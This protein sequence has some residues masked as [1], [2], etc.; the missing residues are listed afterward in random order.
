MI[1]SANGPADAKVCSFLMIGQSNMAGRGSL[2]E[3]EPI[4]N[5]NCYVLRIGYWQKMHEPIN[6]DRSTAGISLA[7]SF[8]DDLA[9][10]SGQPIG[11]IPCAYGGS[12]LR[13][14]MPGEILYEHAVAMT[15]IA[16]YT[17]N[18]SGILWH[19]GEN[20]CFPTFDEAA[21]RESFLSFV[22]TLR[23]DL[24]MPELPL[25]LGEISEEIAPSWGAGENPKRLNTLLNQLAQE[26][27]HC[28]IVSAQGLSLQSDG[29]HF[30]AASCR[31]LGHRYFKAYIKLTEGEI[32]NENSN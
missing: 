23:A 14:W 17:S 24:D 5:P 11:L 3:V 19:Q 27:P 8:A 31:E 2:N 28:S 22:Q 6:P 18:L 12:T 9:N 16:K 20:N 30:D 7:A 29:I 32:P 21:Y 15:N 1:K 25:I 13:R 4:E 26:I 10:Y